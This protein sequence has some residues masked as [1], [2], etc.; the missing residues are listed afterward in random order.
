MTPRQVLRISRP[1]FWLYEAGTFAVGAVA[2]GSFGHWPLL[3]AWFAYFLFPANF[4][5]YGVNDVFDYETDRRNAKKGDYEDLLPPSEHRKVLRLA[6]LLTAPFLP[7]LL[8]VPPGALL[9]FALFLAC[10]VWYSAPPVRAKARP[11]LDSLFSAG[12]Y[13]ATAWFAYELAGNPVAAPWALLAGVLWCAAMH[14]YS[15]VP[16][17]EADGGAGLRTV[18]TVLGAERT[19]AA[20]AALYLAA[21]LLAASALGYWAAALAVPYL[22]LMA[23]SYRTARAGGSVMGQY[24][25]FPYL[26]ACAGAVIWWALALK[27]F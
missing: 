17:I 10:A 14:A 26:N 7:L 5:I 13:V 9:P 2:A 19:I 6:A 11:F 24:R 8:F 21:G 4:L 25:V 18:A 22:V 20:C 1:R 3:L 16:D 23:S 27:L 15:A 12:H